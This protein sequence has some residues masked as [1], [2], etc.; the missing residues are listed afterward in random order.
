MDIFQRTTYSSIFIVKVKRKRDK[1]ESPQQKNLPKAQVSKRNKV[2]RF[3][4]RKSLP[5][6]SE[7]KANAVVVIRI[8]V[9]AQALGAKVADA[10]AETDRSKIGTANVHLLQQALPSNQEIERDH[11]DDFTGARRSF[12]AGQQRLLPLPRLAGGA[13]HFVLAD[14]VPPQIDLFFLCEGLAIVPVLIVEKVL[15]LAAHVQDG[16]RVPHEEDVGFL[17]GFQLG[18]GE[19]DFT[20]LD[21]LF[22]RE[23]NTEV[24]YRVFRAHIACAHDFL[25]ALLAG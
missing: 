9:D 15:D 21:E 3:K 10:D 7:T 24:L 17:A 25:G 4:D 22:V 6:G 1:K 19:R 11:E 20:N 5:G 16:Q 8:A 23:R 2:S 18:F 14:E 12:V 13:W